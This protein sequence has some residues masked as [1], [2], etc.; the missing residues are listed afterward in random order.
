VKV[1]GIRVFIPDRKLPIVKIV[2]ESQIFHFDPKEAGFR[3]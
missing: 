2:E 3:P 1:P